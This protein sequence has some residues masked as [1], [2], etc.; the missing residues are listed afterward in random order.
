MTCE[1]IMFSDHNIVEIS[2]LESNIDPVTDLDWLKN[3]HRS[4]QTKW[5]NFSEDEIYVE[6]FMADLRLVSFM[7]IPGHNLL[8]TAEV[9]LELI[10]E[11][12]S[13]APVYDSG[14]T[15]IGNVLPL[16]IWTA[17]IDPYGGT[18]NE[19]LDDVI[20]LWLDDPVLA[21]RWRVTI[22]HKYGY[23][24]PAEPPPVVVSD[25]IYQQDPVTGILSIEAENGVVESEA[26]IS[27]WE[28]DNHAGASNGANVYYSDNSSY[29]H[30]GSDGPKVK[31]EFTATKSGQYNV[32]LRMFSEDVGG[33]LGGYS[34]F[35]VFNGHSTRKYFTS[36]VNQGWR[37]RETKTITLSAG[38]KY[39]IYFSHRHRPL[40][41]DKLVLKPSS[42]SAPTGT[43]P[44][45]SGFGTK[46]V[47]GGT[48][49]ITSTDS[50]NLRMLMLGEVIQLEKN[51]S[52][53]SAIKF[54]T[55]PELHTSFSGFAIT[56]RAQ[57]TAKRLRLSLD[58][59]TQG[60]R[61]T[62]WNYETKLAGKPFLVSPYPSETQWFKTNYFFLARFE[63]SL[64]YK[65][66]GP[67]I[68]RTSINLVEV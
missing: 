34:I 51:F 62:L 14:F 47:D 3:E 63:D 64:E 19:S 61:F 8:P 57:R 13:V 31:F 22:R 52:Y 38:Q 2:E 9:R 28:N 66:V 21:N 24:P 39:T 5:T 26:G 56:S 20:A 23:V 18:E 17:G 25:G 50:M 6:G 44:T 59:M 60:D 27:T 11:N 49:A 4:R 45:E 35:T 7:A 67:N 15:L 68:H 12:V 43:G 30:T 53:G 37:W 42:D 16:G 1:H 36:I 32:W 58:S 33:V 10:N 41:V 46:T 54:L 65:H 48:G 40:R 55:E 29:H